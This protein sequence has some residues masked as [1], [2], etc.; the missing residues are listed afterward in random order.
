MKDNMKYWVWISS[1]VNLP[2]VKRKLLLDRYGSPGNLWMVEEE[3][4]KHMK[5]LTPKMV[6]HIM[7]KKLRAKTEELLKRITDDRIDIITIDDD[8]YPENLRYIYDPP[9]V[10]YS[11]GEIKGIEPCIAVVGSRR[12]TSYGLDTSELLS[13]QLSK[14]GFTIVS[15]MARG[16]DSK[17]HSG[18]LKAGGRTIAV[19]G[20]GIDIIYPE[21]NKKL[22]ER[23]LENGAVISEY[24]PGMPPHPF[25]FPARNR[26]ISGMSRAVAVIEASE[27]SG[28]LITADY[29]LEQGRDVF[30]VPG[31]INCTNSRG[32]NKLIRD[33]A[34][35]IMGIDDILDELKMTDIANNSFKDKKA[36]GRVYSGLDKDELDVM[37][38]VSSLPKYIDEIAES[39]NMVPHEISAI[40]ILL[41]LKGLVEQLP[42][43]RYKLLQKLK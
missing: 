15:G 3:T 20:C 31:N 14:C 23:I 17:A 13:Y 26:I 33:G 7:D 42:G 37:R 18:A 9:L 39:C 19:L 1:L 2:P 34:R 36:C 8:A 29:A 11:R 32:T 25:N 16:V 12:A 41:E 22:M 6:E 43:K 30:A 4:L 27:G 5:F 35:I 21:E 40:L 10:L 28:S 24:L 38:K